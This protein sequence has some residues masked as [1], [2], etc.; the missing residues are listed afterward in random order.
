MLHLDPNESIL[1]EVRK[2][3]FVFFSQGVFLVIA[4]IIPPIA[5]EFFVNFFPE[6]ITIDGNPT[7]LASFF[8]TLWLL[9]LLMILFIQWTNYYLNVWYITE[10]RIIDV[11]QKGIFHREVSSIRFDKI[12]DITVDVNGV[13]ATFL[14][15]GDVDVQTASETGGNFT[16][17][18]AA[19]PDAVRRIV[20]SQHNQQAERTQPV[21]I[22]DNGYN[23]TDGGTTS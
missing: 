2:H 22:V 3:W 21:K 1:L 6:S 17:R 9:T 10:K 23:N 20:F 5:Y 7:A 12:Q 18:S 16:M 4:T 14:N 15:F 11:V 19:N 13:I 8:Y